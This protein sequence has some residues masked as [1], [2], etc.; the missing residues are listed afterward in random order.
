MKAH[1]CGVF[2][3]FSEIACAR[4]K[5]KTGGCHRGKCMAFGSSPFL[6]RGIRLVFHD[7]LPGRSIVKGTA[8]L[9][10]AAVN[11][12]HV[13]IVIGQ[14]WD[15]SLPAAPCFNVSFAGIYCMMIVPWFHRKVIDF[16]LGESLYCRGNI[17]L[18]RPEE[19]RHPKTSENLA[20]V[21]G[22]PDTI[23][24]HVC[25]KLEAKGRWERQWSKYWL[26]RMKR[27]YQG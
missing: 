11:V 8:Y 12:S 3:K 26:W 17:R 20:G 24:M 13:V 2:F 25:C 1:Q 15:A 6:L 18:R 10:P 4:T 7:N 5:E 16:L 14:I 22:R 21:H 9:Q 27:P 23:L 19:E